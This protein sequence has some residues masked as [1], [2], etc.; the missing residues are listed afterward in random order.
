LIRVV[1]SGTPCEAQA[2][3]NREKKENNNRYIPQQS[4]IGSVEVP[5]FLHERQGK[6]ELT[7]L[8]ITEEGKMAGLR[9]C[10]EN[11]WGNSLGNPDRFRR[12]YRHWLA[13]SPE[14]RI[15][16]SERKE[17]CRQ[18]IAIPEEILHPHRAEPYV[19]ES[20]TQLGF[21]HH[22]LVWKISHFWFILSTSLPKTLFKLCEISEISTA[23]A[24][25][26]LPHLEN[27]SSLHISNPFAS[28]FSQKH[29]LLQ[30]QIAT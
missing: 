25:F 24:R 4:N 16:T 22:P 9:G 2:R 14:W 18:D 19:S 21:S 17:G 10:K 6:L 13:G 28:A 26:S 3:L 30:S 29:I 5:D 15:A 7:H 27:G 1:T 20:I 11:M 23:A 8:F 12:S